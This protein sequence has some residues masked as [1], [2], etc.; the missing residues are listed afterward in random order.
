MLERDYL[1]LSVADTRA[2]RGAMAVYIQRPVWYCIMHLGYAAGQR[3]CQAW[4]DE[5]PLIIHPADLAG[6]SG[7]GCPERDMK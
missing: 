3:G 4:L 1:S 2:Q 5:L 6:S 7:V